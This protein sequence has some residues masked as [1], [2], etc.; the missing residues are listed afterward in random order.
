MP[1]LVHRTEDAVSRSSRTKERETL[2]ELCRPLFANTSNAF[3]APAS[4]L[5]IAERMFVGRAAVQ[6]HLGRLY[7]KFGI[8]DEAGDRR[9]ELANQAIER[10][11]C[12]SS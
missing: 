9:R 6:A 10:A 1:R 7:D 2:V 4:V 3:R 12:D 11:M 5:E 8:Y